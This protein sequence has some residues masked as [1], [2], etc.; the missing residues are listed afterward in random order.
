MR[1]VLVAEQLHLDVPGVLDVPLDVHASVAERGL[2]LARRDAEPRG[3]LVRRRR[4]GP[5]PARRPRPR[6]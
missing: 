6:P 4:R 2:G 1:A 3:E 5:S